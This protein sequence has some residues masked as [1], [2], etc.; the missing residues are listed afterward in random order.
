M[1]LKRLKIHLNLK[2]GMKLEMIL[3]VAQAEMFYEYDTHDFNQKE[4]ETRL[5]SYA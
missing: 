2:S 1:S 3:F 4:A 5:L